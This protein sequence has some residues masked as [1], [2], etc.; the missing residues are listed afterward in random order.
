MQFSDVN[1]T[2][3]PV[4]LESPRVR[5]RSEADVVGHLVATGE[6]DDGIDPFTMKHW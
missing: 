3:D 1:A 5:L 4:C 2:D 6:V